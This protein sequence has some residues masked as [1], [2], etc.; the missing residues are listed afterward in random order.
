MNKLISFP[1]V[2]IAVLSL[3]S[4]LGLGYGSLDNYQS[5][6]PNPE[7]VSYLT[8][9]MIA[10]DVNGH[11]VCF[12]NQTAVSESGQVKPA[13]NNNASSPALWTN[14]T[15]LVT[16]LGV[17]P[18]YQNVYY[19]L[20]LDQSGTIEATYENFASP[21]QL[22]AIKDGSADGLGVNLASSLGLIGAVIGIM[23][24]ATVVGIKVLGS[25]IS[26]FGVSTIVFGTF[27]LLVWGIFSVLS[28]SMLMQIAVFGGLLY[29][30]LTVMYTV[31]IVSS[32]GSSGGED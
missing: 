7:K 6:F 32:L 1:L 31:G 27:Y 13:D 19:S 15:V 5:V 18:I 21:D 12:R 24:L 9:N 14:E 16:Y 2:V 8:M 11:P 17:I 30:A 20:Y 25:G 23:A 28:L 10:W 29:F 22:V 3:L 26:E 4:V